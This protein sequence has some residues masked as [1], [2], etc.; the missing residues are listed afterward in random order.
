MLVNKIDIM[1]SKTSSRQ[2]PAQNLKVDTIISQ[3][4]SVMIHILN[5]F[6]ILDR[7]P[8]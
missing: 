3:G 1:V 7:A 2:G 8:I 5:R 6:A 4:L